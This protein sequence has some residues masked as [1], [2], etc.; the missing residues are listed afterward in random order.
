MNIN[1]IKTKK[2]K[3]LRNYNFTE[4]LAISPRD[5]QDHQETGNFTKRLTSSTNNWKYYQ[6]T[7]KINKKLAILPRD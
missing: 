3:K 4:R 6:E 2:T 1:K 5:W 7:D